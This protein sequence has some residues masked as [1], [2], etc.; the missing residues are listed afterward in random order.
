M[1]ENERK[2]EEKE[3]E[4]ERERFKLLLDEGRAEGFDVDGKTLSQVAVLFAKKLDETQNELYKAQK[5]L[6]LMK[7]LYEK[8]KALYEKKIKENTPN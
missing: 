3:K 8:E 4:E 5:E 2:Q 7:A 1:K 6:T